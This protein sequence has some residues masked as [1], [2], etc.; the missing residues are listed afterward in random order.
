LKKQID[1]LKTQVISAS[2]PATTE[3]VRAKQ[4]EQNSTLSTGAQN[5]LNK[6]SKFLTK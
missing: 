1:N 4:Q 3:Q 5:L 2:I 6:Y